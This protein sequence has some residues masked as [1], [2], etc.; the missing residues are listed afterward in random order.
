M[1]RSLITLAVLAATSGMY[2]QPILADDKPAPSE[3]HPA[4]VS[5]E[6]GKPGN[7]ET[8]AT[9]SDAERLV[10]YARDN[11]S[12]TAMLTAVQMIER[13]SV[14]E[15][16][17]KLGAKKSEAQ[18]ASKTPD[19][20]AK[21]G[22]TPAPTL[23]PVKLLAE[24]ATWAKGDEH[25]TALIAV[26]KAKATAGH[27]G[28]L[29]A[30]KGPVVHND[31]V[32]SRSIDTYNIAFDGGEIARVSVIGDGDTDLDLYVYDMNGNLIIK[33]DGPTDHCGV[34]FVPNYTST[35]TIRVVNNGYVYNRYLLITN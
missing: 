35:F 18:P 15:N 14:Q 30:T 23:D 3:Q 33:D 22:E 26:E 12:P 4:N 16:A 11:E 2:T 27:V 34:W 8:V 32:N 20:E 10:A 6:K 24:A 25:M 17:A 1:K 31:S 28:T 29:G 5:M 9:L 19:K 7:S 13:I 21:K